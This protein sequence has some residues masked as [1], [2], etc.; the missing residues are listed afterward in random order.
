MTPKQRAAA[1]LELRT[2]DFVPTMEID[3]ELNES[4]TGKKLIL[5]SELEIVSGNEKLKALH[6]NID[7]YITTAQMLDYSAIT[8]HPTPTPGYTPGNKYYPTLDDELYVINTLYK[9]TGDQLLIAAGIDATYAIPEGDDIVEFSYRLA[10]EPDELLKYADTYTDWAIDQMK[11]MIDSGASVMYNC[12]DYCFNQGPFISPVMFEQFIYPFLYRQTQALRNAG[13]YVI[14]HTDGNILP[15]LEMIIDCQPHAI[16][17]IDPIAGMDIAEVKK[18]IRNRTAIMGNVDSSALQMGDEKAIVESAEY[19]LEQG[20]PGGGYIFST[21]NSV[22]EGIK[23]ENYQ[24]ML[25]VRNRLGSYE[26]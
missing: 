14:K 15:I 23:I 25:E 1:A 8:V 3:F 10:D 7:V 24:L 11:Q 5:G 26:V 21:C 2:P 4:L 16:H 17:S 18:L 19:A 12:S 6:H 20:M 9:E 13:A 22:F